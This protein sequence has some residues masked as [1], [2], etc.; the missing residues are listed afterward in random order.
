MQ[1]K[2]I[3]LNNLLFTRY[4]WPRDSLVQHNNNNGGGGR[5]LRPDLR[6]LKFNYPFING[7]QSG[8]SGT[9][10]FLSFFFLPRHEWI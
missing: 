10:N 6:I 2:T 9:I 1:T 3:C 5:S 4:L 7:G 8:W